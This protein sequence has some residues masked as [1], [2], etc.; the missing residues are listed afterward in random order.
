[1]R[2]RI[3]SALWVVPAAFLAGPAYG[4]TPAGP[5]DWWYWHHD[6]FGWGH[7]VFGSLMML[8]FWGGAILLIV[9]AVRYLGHGSAGGGEHAT[10]IKTPV[11]ILEERFARG[12]IDKE[13]FEERKRALSR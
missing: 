13:E 10:A 6:D 4:Q 5:P 8:L 11:Q 2:T 3:T 9:L 1:M 7:M 12:E